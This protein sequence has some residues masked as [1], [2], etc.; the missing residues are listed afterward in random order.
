MEER[1]AATGTSRDDMIE[2]G[3]VEALEELHF[4]EAKHRA[5]TARMLALLLVGILGGSVLLHYVVIVA[6]VLARMDTA[7][8]QVGQIFNIWLPVIASLVSAAATFYF[9]SK[10]RS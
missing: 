8:Q 10:E 6:L 9:T 4:H 7:V 1:G 5:D 2:G 3:T